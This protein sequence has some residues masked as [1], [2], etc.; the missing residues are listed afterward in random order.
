MNIVSQIVSLLILLEISVK[1]CRSV[2]GCRTDECFRH[3]SADP[4]LSPPSEC[5]ASRSNP[6][7]GSN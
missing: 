6:S 4:D 2:S 7:A 3:T 5:H 1:L